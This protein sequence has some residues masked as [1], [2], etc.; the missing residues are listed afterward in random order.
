LWGVGSPSSDWS[1]SAYDDDS[2][3]DNDSVP[4]APERADDDFLAGSGPHAVPP[5]DM[6]TATRLFHDT[7][8][9]PAR[10]H[11]RALE[12]PPRSA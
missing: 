2:D 6:L 4:P 11:A 8:L 7:G 9:R 12:L 1:V 10:G 5:G 3:D